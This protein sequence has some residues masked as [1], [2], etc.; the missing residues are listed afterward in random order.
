MLRIT[1][2]SSADEAVVLKLE[3]RLI[4]PWVEL[5]RETC[6]THQQERKASL[7]LDLSAVDFASKEGLDLLGGLQKKGI[8][9]VSWSPLLKELS[10]SVLT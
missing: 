10:T 3:G 4:E 9:C 5:L 6:Q 7:V 2:I 8:R 1:P